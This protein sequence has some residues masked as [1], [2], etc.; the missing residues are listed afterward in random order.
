MKLKASWSSEG[1]VAAKRGQVLAP[2]LRRLHPSETWPAICIASF[3]DFILYNYSVFYVYIY[4]YI[5]IYICI[6]TI[7]SSCIILCTQ[8]NCT[9]FCSDVL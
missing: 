1:S 8:S 4:T 6:Y 2:G 7:L 3:Y 5:Y 9:F